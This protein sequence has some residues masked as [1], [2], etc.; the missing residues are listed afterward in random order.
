[1]MVIVQFSLKL[2][3]VDS[4]IESTYQEHYISTSVWHAQHPNAGRNIQHI[5]IVIN[6]YSYLITNSPSPKAG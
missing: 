4:N 6:S 2:F 5:C 1:M 3:V